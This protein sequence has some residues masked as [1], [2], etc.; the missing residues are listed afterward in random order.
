LEIEQQH[1][2][3][4][5]RYCAWKVGGAFDLADYLKI[6]ITPEQRF[7]TL[8]KDRMVVGDD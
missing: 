7:E 4:I 5:C 3:R 2:A 1:I 8:A 6:A